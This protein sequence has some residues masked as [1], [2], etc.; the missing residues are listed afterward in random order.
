[1]VKDFDLR[2]KGGSICRKIIG[3][4]DIM[5]SLGS[6]FEKEGRRLVIVMKEGEVEWMLIFRVCDWF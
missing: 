3:C 2:V 4:F 5:E 6:F 1:M